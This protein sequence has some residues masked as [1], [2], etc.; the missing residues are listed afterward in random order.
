MKFSPKL[1]SKKL[2]MISSFW[3][4]F[5]NFL[6][7]KGPIFCPKSGLEKSQYSIT[8]GFKNIILRILTEPPFFRKPM[9]YN[10]ESF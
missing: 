1:I 9:S 2:E 7:E 5:A 6:I 4:V 8:Q 10:K 3:E